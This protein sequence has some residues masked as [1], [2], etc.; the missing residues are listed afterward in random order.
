ML[1]L[2]S[3]PAAYYPFAIFGLRVCDMALDTLRVLFVVRGRK[4]LAW[5][6]G[7]FQ[8]ALWVLAITSVLNN[9]DNPWNIAAYAGGF[10]TGN[11]IGM[12]IEER[13]AIGH[14][15]LQIISSRRGSA[16]ADAIR[17]AGY[18]ATEMPA[19]GRD[20]TV[21]VISCSVRRRDVKRVR[22]EVDKIDPDAFI[23]V[24]DIRPIHSGFWRA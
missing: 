4:P 2:I 7:F 5:I 6:L 23:T 12:L 21:S 9:L 11:V 15:N 19:R 22:K 16:I 24:E 3:I 20:G 18:A 14:S 8:S 17:N 1:S 10:A 13:L